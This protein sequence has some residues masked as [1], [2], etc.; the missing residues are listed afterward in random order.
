MEV[1][2]NFDKY[3]GEQ[4]AFDLFNNGQV[5]VIPVR[6]RENLKYLADQIYNYLNDNGV[7]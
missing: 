2:F 6:T 4:I 7:I 1:K 3:Q 5:S